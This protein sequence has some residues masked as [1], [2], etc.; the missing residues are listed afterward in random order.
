MNMGVSYMDIG[1]AGYNH[2]DVLHMETGSAKNGPR[3]Y[4]TSK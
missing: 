2:K 3:S 4:C 1:D